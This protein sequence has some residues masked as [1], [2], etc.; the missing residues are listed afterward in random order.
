MFFD[1]K[2]WEHRLLKYARLHKGEMF[3]KELLFFSSVMGISV[4]QRCRLVS[5]C[6]HKTSRPLQC[7]HFTLVSLFLRK[8]V[9]LGGLLT[10]LSHCPSLIV[11]ICSSIEL[12]I[13]SFHVVWVTILICIGRNQVLHME[14]HNTNIT[15][16]FSGQWNLYS[17]EGEKCLVKKGHF[18]TF[19]PCRLACL[20][21]FFKR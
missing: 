21:I 15:K 1:H 12:I 13:V 10:S 19:F 18:I 4:S 8:I 3:L 7:K 17:T 5:R 20:L 9:S 6:D 14:F 11:L 2:F 16:E